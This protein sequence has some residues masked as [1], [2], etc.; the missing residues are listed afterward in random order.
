MCV[1]GYTHRHVICAPVA[2]AGYAYN[3]Y[4]NELPNP[5]V[6]GASDLDILWMMGSTLA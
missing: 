3:D 2:A 6:R 1:V 5:Q 4:L